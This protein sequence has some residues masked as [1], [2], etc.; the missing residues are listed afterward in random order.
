MRGSSPQK[1]WLEAL[2]YS[3]PPPRQEGQSPEKISPVRVSEKPTCI[4]LRGKRLRVK[5]IHRAPKV[6]TEGESSGRFH[7][8]D[9][10][11]HLHLEM[12]GVGQS[13]PRNSVDLQL[14]HWGRHRSWET[15][16]GDG[17]S[18]WGNRAGMEMEADTVGR[19]RDGDGGGHRR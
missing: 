9:G 3:H 13:K 14:G 10:E 7:G 8:L 16:G 5:S 4:N 19:R 11:G 12:M 18:G 2:T 17:H 1:M 15:L 6:Y